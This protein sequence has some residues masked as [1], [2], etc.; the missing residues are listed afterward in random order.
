MLNR[1]PDPTC[2][3]YMMLGALH[4]RVH[5]DLAPAPSL[6]PW[7]GIWYN[8]PKIESST[9]VLLSCELHCAAT[10]F[11]RDKWLVCDQK[12]ADN[13]VAQAGYGQKLVRTGNR[14]AFLSKR[15]LKMLWLKMECGLR[16]TPWRTTSFYIDN[17]I[18]AMLQLAHDIWCAWAASCHIHGDQRH[19]PALTTSNLISTALLTALL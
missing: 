1:A 17:A 15:S 14:D 3:E 8:A 4:N 19:V 12:F 10:T 16:A 7:R 6:C 5:L 11:C 18:V 2:M 13:V 9:G